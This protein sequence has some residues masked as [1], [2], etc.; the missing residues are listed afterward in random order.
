MIHDF[1]RGCWRLVQPFRARR[2]WEYWKTS[3]RLLR[4][5][6][7][8]NSFRAAG[9]QA[10]FEDLSPVLFDR[11]SS[12]QSG[13]GHYF[14]QDVWAL[15]HLK[16]LAPPRHVDVGSRIDGFAG[17]A[18]A[19]CPILYV[20]IRRPQ[21][22]LAYFEFREGSIL[23]LPFQNNSV[24]SLS[25]LHVVEHIG[26][27]RYGD[28]ID[29]RGAEKAMSELQRV[30]AISGQLL[31]SVPVGRERTEFNAQRIWH[32]SKPVK[33]L[34]ELKLLEFAAVNDVGE[35]VANVAPEELI[36]AR[37]A[38]GLYRFTKVAK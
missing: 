28:L 24:L 33:L 32:P 7:E 35:F 1:V 12:T 19:I 21:F 37:Y 15:R 10:A 13:G 18:T 11:T 16:T 6:N 4:F 2:P 25:C 5:L 8:R 31:F 17:Q 14:F 9:G 29:P 23:Q 22:S 26:L 38:C 3:C 34:T 27:G 30:L 20:D 36:D